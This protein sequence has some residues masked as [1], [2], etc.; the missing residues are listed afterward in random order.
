MSL[1]MVIESQYESDGKLKICQ[2]IAQVLP[3]KLHVCIPEPFVYVYGLVC[4]ERA[5]Q[6]VEILLIVLWTNV[7]QQI[8]FNNELCNY[9]IMRN[10]CVPH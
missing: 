5:S 2:D 10:P 4:Y 8:A 1:L 7:Y 6:I 3:S 9:A